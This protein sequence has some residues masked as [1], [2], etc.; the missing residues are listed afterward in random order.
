[1]APPRREAL[2]WEHFGKKGIRQG[3]WKYVAD[4]NKD[5]ELYDME[6][7]RTELNP[8]GAKYPEKAA[9]LNALWDAWAERC[10]VNQKD[11]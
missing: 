9:Q 5:W 4:K 11:G 7:D 10:G 1:M 8:L 3:K 6:E 2:Y